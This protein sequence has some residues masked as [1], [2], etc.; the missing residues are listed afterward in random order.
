I[1]FFAFSASDDSSLVGFSRFVVSSSSRDKPS[2][3]FSGFVVSS[4]SRDKS[5]ARF[6]G[7][8]VSSSSRDK[9]SARFSGF[10]V[11]SSARDK[12]THFFV[13]YVAKLTMLQF[14]IITVFFLSINE[15]RL[16][17]QDNNYL[18][19][20]HAFSH[21]LLFL[22]FKNFHRITKSQLSLFSN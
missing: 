6:S 7:F 22:Y 8:V 19:S 10:V 12:S 11:S 16:E 21:F 9:S 18:C 5:S 17:K 13:R 3:R 15:H 1:V 14:T 4:S 2:A 20:I